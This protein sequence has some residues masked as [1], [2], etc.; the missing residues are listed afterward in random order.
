MKDFEKDFYKFFNIA[1]CGKT[2]ENHRNRVKIELIKKDDY[3][4]NIKQQSK[5]TFNGIHK[6]YETND[7]YTFN[8]NEVLMHNPLYPGFAILELSK[9]LIDETY[10]D[11]LLPYFG[12]KFLQLHYMDTDSFLLSVKTKDFIKDLKNLEDI[13]DF[14]NLDE[15]HDIFS[16]KNKKNDW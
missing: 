12:E 3:E 16:D 2:K 5:L 15:N 8:Q 14:S 10:Y 9:F 4:K 11:K 6:S 1:F 7:G 13:F